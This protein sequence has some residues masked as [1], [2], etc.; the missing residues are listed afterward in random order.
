M[1]GHQFSLRTLLAAIAGVGIGAGLW[2]AEP[3][4]Q[5]G[6]VTALLLTWVPGSALAL[7]MHSTG[8]SRTF[9]MVCAVH[10]VLMP[11]FLVR[12]GWFLGPDSELSESFPEFWG[13]APY[14]LLVFSWNFLEFLLI[15]VSAPVVGL[16]CVL[17]H[18]LLIR[19]PEPKA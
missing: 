12:S 1:K 4:W 13:N 3:S 6:A 7:S 17:T 11:L 5:A 19:P 8:K 16:L 9:W 15:W 2:V 14:T 10:C 18:W